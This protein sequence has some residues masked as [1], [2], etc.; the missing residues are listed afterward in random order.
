[1]VFVCL[2]IYFGMLVSHLPPGSRISRD[3]DFELADGMRLF[4]QR[5]KNRIENVKLS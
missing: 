4:S 1:M 2:C 3:A 5:E